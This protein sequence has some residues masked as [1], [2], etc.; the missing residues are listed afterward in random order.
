MITVLGN[1]A[2]YV[3][4]R[5]VL[6][7]P[8]PG[9]VSKV[10]QRRPD[11]DSGNHVHRLSHRSVPARCHNVRITHQWHHTHIR[12]SSSQQPQMK[13]YI[14]TVSQKKTSHFNFRHNFAI[15]WDILTIF[16]APCSGLI[17]R[18]CSLSHTHHRCE[19]FTWR[20]V[21]HDVIQA[22]AHCALTPDF[23][24][25]DLW[26]LNSPYFNPVDYS[27]WSI[28]QEKVYQTHTER[29]SMSWNIGQFRCG[30]SWTTDILLQL[31]DSGDTV[32]V[33]VTRVWKLKG[34]ILNE[35]CVEFTCSPLG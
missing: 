5:R 21:T 19:A 31:S 6:Q 8:C 12:F 11:A 33:R 17:A 20:D 18:S 4:N 16:E 2:T 15:C 28:M 10:G 13:I 24:P 1:V 7:W 26:P 29:I 23:I 30:R 32:S 3:V 27:F 22:V 34:D 35:I 25:P 9:Y 14:Y